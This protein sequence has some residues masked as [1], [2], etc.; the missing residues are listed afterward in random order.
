MMYFPHFW[1]REA[2]YFLR[3]AL[4]IALSLVLTPW[5][6]AQFRASIQGTVTDMQGGVIPG[7]KLT[8]TNV[9][10]NETQTRTS[11]G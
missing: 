4:M 10:T 8:L 6:H 9:E 2:K 5:A 1:A 3:A 11:N 7:A